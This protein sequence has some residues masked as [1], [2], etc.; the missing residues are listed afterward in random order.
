MRASGHDARPADG[1]GRG[2]A[3]A[4]PATAAAS[5]SSTAHRSATGCGGSPR[6]SA[7]PRAGSRRRSGVSPAMLSQLASARRVKIGDPAVLARLQLL[8]HRCAAGP[9]RGRAAVDALLA[10][11]AGAQLQLDRCGRP[12]RRVRPRAG[13]R[14][15]D[16][17]RPR[18]PAPSPRRT[19]ADALR[20]VAP[21]ARLAAAAAALTPGFPELAEVLRAAA[22]RPR[23]DR[24][25]AGRIGSAARATRPCRNRAEPAC[26]AAPMS[27][28][29]T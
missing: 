14:R 16:R 28:L 29:V 11:V 18:E 4:S 23:T 6:S 21:P 17:A 5:A 1:P 8:D 26:S 19:P 10:E 22:A 27:V 7:S 15:P 12:R 20:A 13:R 9:P 25:R 2:C 3:P 24:S